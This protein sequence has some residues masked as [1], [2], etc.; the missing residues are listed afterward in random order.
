MG[1]AQLTIKVW[2]TLKKGKCY[3]GLDQRQ[4]GFSLTLYTQLLSISLT[5]SMIMQ[6]GL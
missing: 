1:S 5:Y 4:Y 2:L 6:T 3:C